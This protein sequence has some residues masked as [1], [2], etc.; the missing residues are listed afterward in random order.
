MENQEAKPEAV[1]TTLGELG[2]QLPIGIPD[3]TGALQKTLDVRKWRMPEEQEIGALRSAHQGKNVGKYVSALLAKMC[4]RLGPYTFDDSMKTDDRLLAIAKMS[5]ADA[6]Y[7]YVWLRFKATGPDYPLESQCPYCRTE[8]PFKADLSSLEVVTI[9]DV[10]S[11]IWE[12]ELHDPIEVRGKTVSKLTLGP[13]GWSVIE[14]AD[15]QA[16]AELNTGTVKCRLIY[17]SVRSLD[18]LGEVPLAPGELDEIVK[19]DIEELSRLMDERVVGPVMQIEGRCP[20]P[21]CKRKF[22]IPIEWTTE[23]FFSTSS[24]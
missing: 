7:A 20:S 5:L 24:R 8:F 23:D 14:A 1:K 6:L 18:G 12:Y 22:Q 15:P 4:T 3:K 9:T 11:A 19:Y 17:G 10:Q 21:T 2:P 16:M 13:P